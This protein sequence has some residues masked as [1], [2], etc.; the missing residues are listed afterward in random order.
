MDMVK[1]RCYTSDGFS[2]FC[3]WYEA[4]PMSVRGSIVAVVEGLERVP[5]ARWRRRAFALLSNPNCAGLG[6]I[7]IEKSGVHY[8]ILGFDSSTEEEFILLFGF[9]KDL[10]PAYS[11][12]CPIAKVRKAEVQHDPDKSYPCR[13]S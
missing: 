1:F 4:Q 7:R 8:R 10:D 11:V 6:E 5:R 13:L 12:S 9:R 3:A 2:G